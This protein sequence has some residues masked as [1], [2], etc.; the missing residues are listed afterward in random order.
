MYNNTNDDDDNGNAVLIKGEERQ[1]ENE[2]NEMKMCVQTNEGGKVKRE[3]A[4]EKKRMHNK[5]THTQYN[6]NIIGICACAVHKI[7]NSTV[8][9]HGMCLTHL[10]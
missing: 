3:E 9:H 7:Q 1:S 6:I 2:R 8:Q 10:L 4:K 5:G